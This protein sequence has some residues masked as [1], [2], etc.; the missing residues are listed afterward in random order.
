MEGLFGLFLLLIHTCGILAENVGG[1]CEQ[2]DDG[3]ECSDTSDD[4]SHK[5][6]GVHD[7]TQ[8]PDKNT[9]RDQ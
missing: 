1:T 7:D 2:R 4:E 8:V 5:Y 9:D 3:T 6:T